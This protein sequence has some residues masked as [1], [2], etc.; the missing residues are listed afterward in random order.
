VCIKVDY[1]SNII[2]S[3]PS[4]IELTCHATL[5]FVLLSISPGSR[6]CSHKKQ[7][8]FI[9]IDGSRKVGADEFNQAKMFLQDFVTRLDVGLGRTH[10]GLLLVDRTE[11]TKIEISLGQYDSKNSLSNAIGRI[12]HHKRRRSDM[13]HALE[14]V[15][16]EVR[17]C[18][19]HQSAHAHGFHRGPSPFENSPLLIY[20]R[21]WHTYI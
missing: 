20:Y 19:V 11:K 3:W 18:C 16:N 15:Q 6:K 4:D 10:V 13:A 14:L 2:T 5:N 9:V 1:N 7:D 12:K 21:H 17:M 8:L